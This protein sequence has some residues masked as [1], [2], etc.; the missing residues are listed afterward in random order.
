MDRLT[1]ITGVAACVAGLSWTAAAVLHSGQPPGCVGA[2]CGI[3]DEMRGST[4]A[5][6][7]L[8][9]VAGVMLAVSVVGLMLL[10]RRGTDP[11]PVAMATVAA[12]EIG[13][14]LLLAAG[15]VATAGDD[16]W[17]GMPI[18]VVPGLALLA[19]GLCL[20]AVTVWTAG[21][22]PRWL[23]PVLLVAVLLLPLVNEQT[24]R[25]LLAVPFGLAWCLVGVVLLGRRRGAPGG[26]Y[27][28]PV[29]V[30]IGG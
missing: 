25:V 17:A 15:L 9:L 29:P 5:V 19:L 27:Q 13:L 7:L 3:T 14:V 26:A 28:R 16:N 12:C 2:G 8:F 24:S 22:L 23:P 20:G 1:G 21:L 4:P 18:L 10:V 11:G 30:R 6:D